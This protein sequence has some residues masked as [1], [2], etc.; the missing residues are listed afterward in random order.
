[1]M[2][3]NF[4]IICLWVIGL[5]I[6]SRAQ[7]NSLYKVYS[8]HTHILPSGIT[9][10]NIIRLTI[11]L[12]TTTHFV[13]P[14][15]IDYVDISTPTVQGDLTEDNL[16]RIRPVSDVVKDG[17]IFTLTVV[18]KNFIIAYEVTV[19]KIADKPDVAHVIT[20]NPN[21]GIL[22]NQSD[23]LSKQ[24]CFDLS[25]A[26]YKKK[27]KI[28]NVRAYNNGLFLYLNGAYVFGDYI[29]LDLEAIL[30]SRIPY[31]IEN[32]RFKITDKKQLKATVQQD[33][34]IEPYYAL[35]PYRDTQISDTWRNM[36]VFKKFTYPTQKVLQIELTEEQYSGRN[37]LLEIPY[38]RI[39]SAIQL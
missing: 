35:Y 20:I 19:S 16:F 38:N 7:D 26:V 5:A 37:I 15:P 36:F 25:L 22:L 8:N 11:P 18:T 30:K 21:E 17:D 6:H 34:E 13:S 33:I 29:L 32:V 3:R 10:H 9:Q 28:R 12:H 31:S 24:Q 39:L 27:K 1:M 23:V 4:F 14:E 2:Q